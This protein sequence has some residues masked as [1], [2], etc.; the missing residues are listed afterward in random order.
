MIKARFKILPSR[1]LVLTES[2]RLLLIPNSTTF[3]NILIVIG[4][5]KGSCTPNVKI[6]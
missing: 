1:T 5:L 3:E 4:L 2:D 6:Y